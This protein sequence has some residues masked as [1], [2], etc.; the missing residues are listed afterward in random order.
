M[1]WVRM[2]ALTLLHQLRLAWPEGHMHR[3]AFDHGSAMTDTC[4]MQVPRPDD[5]KLLLFC[6]LWPP[7][8]FVSDATDKQ[9]GVAPLSAGPYLLAQASTQITSVHMQVNFGGEPECQAESQWVAL[10]CT[11]SSPILSLWR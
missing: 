6:L 7:S 9:G 11:A 5:V 4:C 1:L 10:A 3:R 2:P 8:C